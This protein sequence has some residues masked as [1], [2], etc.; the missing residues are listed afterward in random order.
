MED[1]S[2]ES[3]AIARALVVNPYAAIN[4]DDAL[5]K[6]HDPIVS[7]EAWISANRKLLRKLGPDAYLRLLLDV[8]KGVDPATVYDPSLMEQIRGQFGSLR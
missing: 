7:E 6:K 2:A 4:V 8:L 3:S 1:K 5:A